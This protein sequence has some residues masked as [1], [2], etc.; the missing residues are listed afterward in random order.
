MGIRDSFDAGFF[1]FYQLKTGKNKL[2]AKA[3]RTLSI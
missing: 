3:G 1:R 2:T